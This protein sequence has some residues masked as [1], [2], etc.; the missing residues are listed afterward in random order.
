M[1]TSNTIFSAGTGFDGYDNSGTSD[2]ITQSGVLSTYDTITSVMDSLGINYIQN[3][4]DIISNGFNFSCWG[5]SDTPTQAKVAIKRELP[6]ILTLS[7]LDKN[8]SQTTLD[9]FL[10]HVNGF[11]KRCEKMSKMTSLS[12][13]TREAKR[14]KMTSAI[15]YRDAIL[16]TLLQ[17][18][19][20]TKG[21]DIFVP[22]GGWSAPLKEDDMT[23]IGN[24]DW[25]FTYTPYIINVKSNETQT[26][27]HE[28]DPKTG[29]LKEKST[30]YWWLLGLLFI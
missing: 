13:C 22:K 10:F 19:D 25:E 27:S 1:N 14:F 6:P 4:T 24:S 15:E 21:E 20:I 11:I 29:E 30:S 2:G 17:G 23:R 7:G 5:A 28:I 9:S 8:I 16:N 3:I 12:S 18:Y 26:S